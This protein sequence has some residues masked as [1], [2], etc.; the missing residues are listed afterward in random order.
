MEVQINIVYLNGLVLAS[1]LRIPL[2]FI[3]G[4]SASRN[5]ISLAAFERSI[6]FCTAAV[7]A[8]RH[9][10]EQLYPNMVQNIV[11][12]IYERVSSISP[13]ACP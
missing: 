10:Q 11:F 8:L 9:L 2:T 3:L 4:L 6:S 13:K 1:F 7:L 5:M 12:R